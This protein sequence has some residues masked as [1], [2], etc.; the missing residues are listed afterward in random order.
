P[1]L[2]RAGRGI[3]SILENRTGPEDATPSARDWSALI[4][5]AQRHPACALRFVTCQLFSCAL[6]DVSCQYGGFIISCNPSPN[7]E[8]GRPVA[9]GCYLFCGL[10]SVQSR[11]DFFVVTHVYPAL[12]H[13]SLIRV[14]YRYNI[15]K[16]FGIVPEALGPALENS[17]AHVDR[18]QAHRLGTLWGKLPAAVPARI[19]RRKCLSCPSP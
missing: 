12:G 17:A 16:L 4:E 9:E 2:S 15:F 6:D 19:A 13:R 10:R 8:R 3:A 11:V 14:P 5:R 18:L 1:F 7:L